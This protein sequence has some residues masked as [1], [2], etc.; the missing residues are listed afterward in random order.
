MNMY[1][2][3]GVNGGWGGMRDPYGWGMGVWSLLGPEGPWGDLG[4]QNQGFFGFWGL[5]ELGVGS[6]G[7]GG[8][9]PPL[10]LW[11]LRPY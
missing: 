2:S 10:G 4:A 7:V 9:S 6:G 8:G 3:R 1:F 11:L 5:G